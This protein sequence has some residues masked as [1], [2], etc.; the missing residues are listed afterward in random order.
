[1]KK[2][3]PFLF[4]GDYNPEQWPKETW[5]NDLEVFKQA[6][7]NSA[8]INIFAWDSLQPAEDVYDFSQLDEIMDNLS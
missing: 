4:E 6:Q 1:M 8:S 2:A 5:A 7:I 3:I